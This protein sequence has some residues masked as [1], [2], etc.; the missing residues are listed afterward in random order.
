M[1]NEIK[2]LLEETRESQ[3]RIREIL[4]RIEARQVA[5]SK[6]QAGRPNEP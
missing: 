5:A 3:A 2:K 1:E 6:T 4:V